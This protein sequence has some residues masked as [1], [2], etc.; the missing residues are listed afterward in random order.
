ML[1]LSFKGCWW[2]FQ[3]LKWW[4]TRGSKRSRIESPGACF[5][6]FRGWTFGDTA[7]DLPKVQVLGENRVFGARTKRCRWHSPG[8]SVK[9]PDCWEWMV[10]S[11]TTW[12]V[13]P[14]EYVER[15]IDLWRRLFRSSNV[16]RLKFREKRLNGENWRFIS[17]W[18]C[19]KLK[20]Q[21]T[22]VIHTGSRCLSFFP[23]FFL[24]D[25]Q[26]R[27]CFWETEQRSS[28]KQKRSADVSCQD[29]FGY[30]QCIPWTPQNLHF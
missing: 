25:F 5:S 15:E 13:C 22:A 14:G 20:K 16:S 28:P 30:N 11:G 1:S 27:S 8:G 12:V 24:R 17:F 19:K 29:L 3:R 4:P 26:K 18:I 7:I 10:F 6:L 21:I 2:P 9:F 23:T